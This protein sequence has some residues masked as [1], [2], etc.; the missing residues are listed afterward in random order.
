MAQGPS[1]LATL[2]YTRD[3]LG[4]VTSESQTGLP[5][6]ANTSYAYTKLNQLATAGHHQLQ[7]RQR[8]TMRRTHRKGSNH[9]TPPTNSRT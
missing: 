6:N 9:T 7:L 8:P 3:P 2:A 5:E 4:Q 1:T